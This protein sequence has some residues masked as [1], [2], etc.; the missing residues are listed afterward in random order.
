MKAGINQIYKHKNI[1]QINK[2]NEAN[3]NIHVDR[4][5]LNKMSKILI[6]ATNI[7][8]IKMI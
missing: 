7:K 6:L 4:R 2:S 1:N 5:L 3:A 8:I